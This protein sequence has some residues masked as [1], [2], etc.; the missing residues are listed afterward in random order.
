MFLGNKKHPDYKATVANIMAKIG[1]FRAVTEKQSVHSQSNGKMPL[2]L[3][4]SVNEYRKKL[5]QKLQRKQREH[6]RQR[7]CSNSD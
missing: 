7:I 6:I 3:R 5:L 1:K 4:S 2:T